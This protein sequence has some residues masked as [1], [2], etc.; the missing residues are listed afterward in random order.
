MVTE[1]ILDFILFVMHVKFG[2]LRVVGLDRV[3]LQVACASLSLIVTLTELEVRP[4]CLKG[5][6]RKLL[7]QPRPS[8][9]SV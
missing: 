1:D 3:T 5:P 8:S 9:A 6:L 4:S 2:C 7:T